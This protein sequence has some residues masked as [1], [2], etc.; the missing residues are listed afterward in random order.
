MELKIERNSKMTETTAITENIKSE[1]NNNDP[2]VQL[3]ALAAQRKTWAAQAALG[4]RF[5]VPRKG[6]DSVSTILY[7]P[8]GPTDGQPLPVLFHMHGGAWVGGDAVLLESFCQLLAD[9]IPAMVVNINYKKADVH[10]LPYACIEVADTVKFFMEHSQKYGIDTNY[11][12]VGGHSAGAHLAAG[13]ALMLKAE[14]VQ[15]ACQ[16]LVYPVTDVREVIGEMAELF[17]DGAR[18]SSY[19]SPLGAADEELS[20]TAPAIFI[21]CGTDDLRQQG[22]SYA[23]R[24][25]D[26]G[27][28]VK[29]KEYAKAE[30]GFLEVNRP[31]YTQGDHRQNPEQAA[32]ARECERYLICELKSYL[33]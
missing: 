22:I 20:N 28:A 2:K 24:L 31:D 12:A 27:V 4:E 15:L 17:I 23:K 14:G 13:A 11:M 29:V 3:E 21:F 10:P 6:N 25:I 18:D 33:V 26:V 16:M 7:R 19:M 5:E 30:H 32:Y 8:S 9:E 1:Q